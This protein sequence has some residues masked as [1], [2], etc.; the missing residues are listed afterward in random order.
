M[1]HFNEMVK[2]TILTSGSLYAG[3]AVTQLENISVKNI[4]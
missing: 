2:K 3:M 1:A 4:K